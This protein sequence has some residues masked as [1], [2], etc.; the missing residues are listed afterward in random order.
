MD[1]TENNIRELLGLDHK[2]HV[3]KLKKELGE[4]I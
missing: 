4:D 3:E 1:V 2:A